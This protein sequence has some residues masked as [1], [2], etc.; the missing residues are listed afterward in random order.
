MVRNLTIEE[1]NRVH[2]LGEKAERISKLAKA[3]NLN[4]IFEFSFGVYE[5]HAYVKLSCEDLKEALVDEITLHLFDKGEYE[6]ID[7]ALDLALMK[8]DNGCAGERIALY[9]AKIAELKAKL[10]A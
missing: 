9:E 6:K 10:N 1:L 3:E 5:A 2:A 8:A 4:F 7:A